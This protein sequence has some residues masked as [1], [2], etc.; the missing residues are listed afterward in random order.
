MC[1]PKVAFNFL[2][3][4]LY[5]PQP[6]WHIVSCH[7]EPIDEDDV[8]GHGFSPYSLPSSAVNCITNKRCS[9]WWFVRRWH[10][11]DIVLCP[12]S[13]R[14]TSIFLPPSLAFIHPP[15]HRRRRRRRHPQC[16]RP[17]RV[18]CSKHSHN[19][20]QCISERSRKMQGNDLNRPNS[21]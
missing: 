17:Q 13:H 18:V 1:P 14:T 11:Y 16:C 8:G 2:S 5:Q 6:K 9:R 19:P 7:R 10:S 20:S 4:S 21:T 3:L 15:T 12:Q